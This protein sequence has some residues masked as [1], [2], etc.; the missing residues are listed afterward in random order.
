MGAAFFGSA[1][2]IWRRHDAHADSLGLCRAAAAS[3][4]IVFIAEWGDLTQ[5]G[6][7]ALAAHYG[8]PITVFVGAT[9]ALWM[10]AGI[11]VFLRN[12]ASKLLDLN[13]TKRISTR[14]VWRCGY[15]ALKNSYKDAPARHDYSHRARYRVSA[16]ARGIVV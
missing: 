10:V 7:A 3:F 11:A 1:V 9:A 12:R 13:R 4:G 16:R 8:A 14:C 15:R 2:L 5:V 6:T